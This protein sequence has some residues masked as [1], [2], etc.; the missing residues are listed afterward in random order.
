MSYQMKFGDK[1]SK[2]E[3]YC[4]IDWKNDQY[5]KSMM[6]IIIFYGG[7]QIIWYLKKYMCSNKDCEK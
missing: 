3:V 5:R 4:N 7:C 2:I 6:R 1:K